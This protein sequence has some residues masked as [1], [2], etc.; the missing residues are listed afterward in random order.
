MTALVQDMNKRLMMVMS[1]GCG[2]LLALCIS[3]GIRLVGS[4][5]GILENPLAYLVGMQVPL[6]KI[7]GLAGD[8]VSPELITDSPYI[9]YF[10]DSNCRACD[11]TY[12]SLKKAT[13]TLPALIVGL[14]HRE[15]LASKLKAQDI[16]APVGYDSTRAVLKTLGISGLP[17]AL[18][19]DKNGIIRQASMGRLSIDRMF[20]SITGF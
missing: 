9:L 3:V 6:F 17:S 18:L 13:A 4:P 16:S 15:D 20:S 12:P 5:P 8:S 11:A 10:T 7:D 1:F 19:V 2:I 14:G